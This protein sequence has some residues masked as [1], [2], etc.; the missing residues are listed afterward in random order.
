MSKGFELGPGFGHLT[1]KHIK[2]LIANEVDNDEEWIK[3]MAEAHRDRCKYCHDRVKLLS[4]LY[5][6]A[7]E[8]KNGS[9]A[10]TDNED[11]CQYQHDV[12]C[13]GVRVKFIY[14]YCAH[15]WI[16]KCWLALDDEIIVH[17]ESWTEGQKQLCRQVVRSAR[18]DKS[19]LAFG[20]DC[21]VENVFSPW[22]GTT[23]TERIQWAER[24]CSE[25]TRKVGRSIDTFN[26][27]ERTH[28]L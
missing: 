12:I 21:P 7:F 20:K 19:D 13:A 24:F 16:I 14:D 4:E 28:R 10:S 26:S 8:H 9:N 18:Q 6:T 17:G 11:P 5:R 1:I 22:R 2:L 23:R 25:L 27:I 3:K 15:E